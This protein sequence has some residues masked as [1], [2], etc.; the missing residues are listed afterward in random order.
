MTTDT[1]DPLSDQLRALV[2]AVDT[3]SF[4]EIR[5]HAA[6]PRTRSPRTRVAI[7][8]A[9]V[10]AFIALGAGVV[11]LLDGTEKTGPVRRP[12]A[13]T[14]PKDCIVTITNYPGCKM[15]AK[16][17]QQYLGFRPRVPTNV[18]EGWVRQPSRLK[19]YRSQFDPASL[20]AG[21]TEVAEFFQFWAPVGTAPLAGHPADMTCSPNLVVRQRIAL[22][23]EQALRTEV[24]TVD[25]GNGHIVNGIVDQSACGTG[26]AIGPYANLFWAT[27]GQYVSITANG[28]PNEQSLAIARSLDR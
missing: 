14:L 1:R 25:L 20:P 28:I 10:I 8:L 4:A 5:T 26:G 17:A 23:G 15:T 6:P 13:T 7:A 3:P 21:V 12:V 22:V 24:G 18:P 27:R 16:R 2:D 9:A 11:A 19:I